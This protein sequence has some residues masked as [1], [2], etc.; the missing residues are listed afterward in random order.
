MVA[1]IAVL[2]GLSLFVI[3]ALDLPFT[4]GVAIQPEALKSEINEFCSYNFVN[5]TEGRNCNDEVAP[6]RAVRS[7]SVAAVA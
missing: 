7:A 5:P 3:L 1:T 4:G 6:S 2:I